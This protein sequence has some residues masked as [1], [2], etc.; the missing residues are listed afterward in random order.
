MV[1]VMLTNLLSFIS[2][3]KDALFLVVCF[4]LLVIVVVVVWGLGW[5]GTFVRNFGGNGDGKL[6]IWNGEGKPIFDLLWYLAIA[7]LLFAFL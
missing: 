4:Y 1:V 5:F 3:Y 6:K 2:V 7:S